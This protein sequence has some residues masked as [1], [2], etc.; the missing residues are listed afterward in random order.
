MAIEINFLYPDYDS[1]DKKRISYQSLVDKLNVLLQKFSPPR[2]LLTEEYLKQLIEYS[3]LLLVMDVIR[4]KKQFTIIGMGLLVSQYTS[5]GLC[6]IIDAV[7]VD[8][9]YSGQGFAKRIFEKLIEKARMENMISIE[10]IDP[11]DHQIYEE[12]QFVSISS[13]LRRLKLN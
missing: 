12:L 1:K 5:L 11:I 7:V 2:P 8:E 10:I 6:G 9:A 13:V 3:H 4:G